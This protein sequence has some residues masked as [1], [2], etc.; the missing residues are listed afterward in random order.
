MNL[1]TI[2]RAS[3]A[4]RGHKIGLHDSIL[5]APSVTTP[6]EN[7]I[8]ETFEAILGAVYVDAGNQLD[9]VTKVIKKLEL[10]DR[11]RKQENIAEQMNVDAASSAV[12]AV[13]EPDAVL[14]P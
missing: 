3:L 12:T 11:F 10:D 9:K 4:V 13:K 7:Q 6:R 5:I 2:T 1:D 14:Q 8:A